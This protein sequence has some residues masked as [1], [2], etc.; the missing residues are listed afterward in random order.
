MT[1]KKEKSVRRSPLLM[2]LVKIAFFLLVGVMLIVQPW[3]RG[4]AWLGWLI[5]IFAALVCAAALMRLNNARKMQKQLIAEFDCGDAV[6]AKGLRIGGAL[7]DFSTFGAQIDA[8]DFDGEHLRFRYSFY[9]R[10]G[11][12]STEDVA[13]P[14]KAEEADKAQAV[15]ATLALPV[16]TDAPAAAELPVETGDEAAEQE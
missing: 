1:D 16:L 6:Y 7:Y 12:R 14:V 3:L 9:A 13:I 8:A 11:G 15:L 2:Q 4:V 5:L 10:R